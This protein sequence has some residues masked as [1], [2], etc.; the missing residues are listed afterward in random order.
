MKS[1]KLKSRSY[2]GI[3]FALV[4]LTFN[5]VIIFGLWKTLDKV[6]WTY[7]GIID[8]ISVILVFP[9]FKKTIKLSNILK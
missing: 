7:K 1:P 2:K 6:P 8:L 4:F 9:D 3:F 5:A